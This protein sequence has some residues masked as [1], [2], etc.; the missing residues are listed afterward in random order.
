[1]A[2]NN[3]L[4]I[5]IVSDVVCPWCVIGFGR[6]QKALKD[7]KQ[8]D[9][10]IR[11]HPFELNPHMAD[12][13]ENLRQHLTE[14]YGTTLQGSIKARA[15]LTELGKEVGFNFNYFDDM[16]MFNTH[17]C[18]QLLLW[19]LDSGKQ[20]QLAMA[21]F[22]KFFTYQGNFSQENLL[23]IVEKVGLDTEQARQVL[24]SQTL[25]PKVKEIQSQWRQQGLQGV[26]AFIFNNQDIIT[27]AQDITVFEQQLAK[28]IY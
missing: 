26:P 2:P 5:D 19:A 25:S 18:H 1:M 15:M 3:T 17:Q 6:L 12:Q 4:N 7:N 10:N 28:Y 21:L 20:T 8:I 27:G 24:T 11:W 16:K 9:A 23:G 13:G 22:E 14:K